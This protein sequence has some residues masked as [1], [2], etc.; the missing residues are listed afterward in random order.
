MATYN[1]T[2]KHNDALLDVKYTIDFQEREFSIEK[3]EYYGI[4]VL[5]LLS[6]IDVEEITEQIR[7]DNE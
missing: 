4:N 3:I 5:P 1:T 6:E 2:V 7:K